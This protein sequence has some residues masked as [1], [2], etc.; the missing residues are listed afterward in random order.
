[1]ESDYYNFEALNTPP[2]HPA[3]DMQDTFYLADG[4][5]MRTHTSSVQIRYMEKNEPP[6]R[7]IAPGRVYRPDSDATHTP[8]FHQIEGLW[9]DKG[10]H[11]GHLKGLLIA[12][13]KDFFGEKIQTRFR[14]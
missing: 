5:L 6:I 11:M 14:P 2:D 4:N 8:M 9:V 1:M 3:R 7:V 12:F 13:L 10:I